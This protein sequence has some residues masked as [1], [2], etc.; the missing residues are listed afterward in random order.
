MSWSDG[1][2]LAIAL[3]NLVIAMATCLA[4][5]ATGFA[6]WA[7]WSGTKLARAAAKDSH[8]QAE[9]MNEALLNAYQQAKLMNEALLD[10]AKANALATRIEF[11]NEQVE[12]GRTHG[13]GEDTEI[14][15]DQQQH[16][17]YQLDEISEKLGVGAGRPC[18]NSPHNAK[19]EGWKHRHAQVLDKAKG[20]QR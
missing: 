20:A 5:V 10:A 18:D 6:A 2:S 19:I 3:F 13:W 1:I 11:Y 4:A 7:A 17:V 12:F 16:L 15:R 8:Q 14:C 9:R